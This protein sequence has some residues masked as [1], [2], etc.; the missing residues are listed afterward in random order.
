VTGVPLQPIGTTLGWALMLFLLP[1]AAVFGSLATVAAMIAAILLIPAAST[2]QSW[3]FLRA[4]P[5]MWIFVGV[6]A[7]LSLVFSVTANELADVRFALNFIALPLAVPVFL[8]AQRYGNP[9][10]AVET[11]AMLCLGGTIAGTVLAVGQTMVLGDWIVTGIGMGPRVLGR[12]VLVLGFMPLA[13]LLMLRSRWR[14][15]FYLAPILALIVV[16]LSDTRGALLA[17]PVIGLIHVAFLLTDR[18]ER[19]HGLIVAGIAFAGLA[20]VTLGSRRVAAIITDLLAGGASVDRSTTER[21]RMLEAAWTLFREK[22]FLGHGWGNFAEVSHPLL[23]RIVRGGPTDRF[24][25]FH[26]DAANLAVSAGT[27]GIIC[28]LA[29]LAAPLVGVFVT[30]RDAFFRVRLYCCLQLSASYLIFGLTDLTFG[31]DLTTALYAFLTAIV[32]GAFREAPAPAA[33]EAAVSLRRAA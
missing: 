1:L 23:G 10:T 19:R 5:A 21:V 24:F 30:P 31:Y 6:F 16:Y 4:Q 20:V 3:S 17:I 25:Q 32:L 2:R 18:H 15:G 28:W 27:I 7:A 22:P 12:V 13:A 29:L 33:L 26:N 8:V 14:L 11:V 9:A